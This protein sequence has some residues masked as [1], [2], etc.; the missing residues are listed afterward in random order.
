MP[1]GTCVQI[2]STAYSSVATGTTQLPIDDTIPQITEG[3]EYMTQAITPRSATN[4]LIITATMTLSFSTAP[5]HISTALF[6]DSTANALA[7]TSSVMNSVTSFLN[8]S[9]THTMT[10][11]TTSST[12]FRIRSGSNVAGTTTFNGLSGARYFGAIPKSSIVI[13]EY[14]V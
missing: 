1:T 7:A 12:T 9:L 14:T 2:A 3:N 8:Y 4:E 13:R 6:Q 5:S 11:G 10:A